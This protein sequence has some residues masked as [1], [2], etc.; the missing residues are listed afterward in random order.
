M[1]FSLER[2]S[3]ELIRELS[4]LLNRHND[5]LGVFGD[6]ALEPDFETYKQNQEIGSVRVFCVR[7][8]GPHKL[9]GYAVY[10]VYPNQHHKNKMQ[11]HQD[12]L[13]LEKE[14]RG[15]GIGTEFLMWVDAQLKAEGVFLIMQS[16][17]DEKHHG[18]TIKAMG[19]VPL[20]TVYMRRL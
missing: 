9:V 14:W 4:P 1:V 17:R 12:V 2:V 3:D 15:K 6:I 13:F 16:V 8:P 20:E 5:E 19:Y 10:F 7:E 11:A 18:R